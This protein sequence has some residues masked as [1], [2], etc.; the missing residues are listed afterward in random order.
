MS[1]RPLKS[2][3]SFQLGPAS[4]GR[5]PGRALCSLAALAPALVGLALL[6]S[7]CHPQKTMSQA[8]TISLPEPVRTGELSVETSIAQRRS[9]R[10]FADSP[11]SIPDLG[12]ILWACQGVTEPMAEAPS[13]FTWPWMGGLRTAPSAGA[14]YPLEIHV[15]VHVVEGL[16][17]GVYHYLPT[18]HS[19]VLGI[20]RDLRA[21]L[22]G[23][24][25]GQASVRNAPVTVVIAG[26]VDRTAAKYGDRAERY[27]HMEVGAAGENIYLQA[28]SLG[29][30]TVFVGAFDDGGVAQVLGL[31]R[32][33]RVFALMPLGHPV[34]GF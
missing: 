3:C 6:P 17:P 25:L 14:L 21:D 33:Q 20:P 15:V 32:D 1:R 12:Q 16:D 5:G 10:S 31:P 23:A 27:V 7:A 24:A 11:V 18:G 26:V 29:L 28:G 34:A 22:S 9:V 30:G 4:G 8:D 2:S 13:G 19:L